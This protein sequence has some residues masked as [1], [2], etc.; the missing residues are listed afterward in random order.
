M[1]HSRSRIRTLSCVAL[2]GLLL[3]LASGAAAA[4]GQSAQPPRRLRV[5]QLVPRPRLFFAAVSGITQKWTEKGGTQRTFDHL[6]LRQHL[7]FE[8][9]N[10]NQLEWRW[11]VALQPFPG[12]AGGPPPGLLAEQTVSS[13]AFMIDFGRIAQLKSGRGPV[14][15]HIRVVPTLHGKPAG[16]ASNT[17]VAHYV[18]GSNN[19]AQIA[20]DAIRKDREKKALHA[21]LQATTALS[22]VYGV[23]I[24]SF[25]AAVFADPNQWGC[26]VIT[27]NKYAEVSPVGLPGVNPVAKYGPGKHCGKRYTGNSYQAKDAWAYLLG[28]AKAYEIV[29]SFY[30][31]AKAFVAAQVANT[32]PCQMLGKAGDD[33]RK[34]AEQ[35]AGMAI[36]AGLTAAGVPPSLPDL[37][38]MAKGQAVNAGV[39]LTC[40]AIENGGGKCS[41]QVRSVLAKAYG[42]GLDRLEKEMAKVTKEPGC[43]NEQ[44]A[45]EH[46]RWPLPCFSDYPGAVE[47]K[48]AP[49]A[50]YQPPTIKMRL[51]RK[52]Q[53][54]AES[55][56]TAALTLD[57]TVPAGTTIEHY[58]QPIDQPVPLRGEPFAPGRLDL[59]PLAPGQSVTV[60]MP[61]GGI[62]PD[63]A[64]FSTTKGGYAKHNGWCYL[65]RGGTGPLTVEARCS[66]PDGKVFSCGGPAKRM[67]QIPQSADCSQ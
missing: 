6:D 5:P 28:W 65:Y 20:S 27:R 17:V 38:E 51:T 12:S 33:C 59:A 40:T 13:S 15:F 55:K 52:S 9:A 30:D 61:L 23:E 41:P 29:S 48:P 63:A 56:V 35:L 64:I 54:V 8:A 11:Q 1:A 14:D 50:V 22:N 34:Y 32:L 18:P 42:A 3:V 57:N 46:G 4:P 24:L 60:T 21:A 19:S 47:F 45:K 53:A 66:A 39:E 10:A 26:V 58:Y 31:D 44:E 62:R 37:D 36:T 7:V 25:E 16:S 49:G 43:G 2:G 67:V